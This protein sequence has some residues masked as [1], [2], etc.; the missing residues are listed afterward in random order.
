MGEENTPPAGGPTFE[1]ITSQEDLDRRIGERLA[2]ER[3]KF[4][5]YDDLK[6]KASK[7]DELQASKKDEL[8]KAQEAIADRDRQLAE[9]PKTARQQAIKFASIA[10]QKGFLDPEDA[11]LNM[12][13][14]VDLA[15]ADAVATALDEVAK[16][17][18]HLVSTKKPL[19][20]RPKV[21]GEETTPPEG[22][23]QGKER[24]A[25]ALRQLRQT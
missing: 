8:Q 22:G 4:S 20:S 7:F 11:L 14:D 21:E 13:D 6:D 9:V 12:S 23:P 5:D 10:A 2:R 15:D 3:A 24:A 16:R 17:K 1:A 25:A 19:P 18:P